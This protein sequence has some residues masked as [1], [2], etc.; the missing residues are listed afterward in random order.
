MTADMDKPDS[1]KKQ[2]RNNLLNLLGFQLCWFAC[3]VGGDVWAAGAVGLF[4]LWHLRITDRQEW[5]LIAGL[6]FA[7]VALDT[8]WYQL[9]LM[10]FPDTV[11]VLIP[12]WLMLL[13]LAFAATLRHSLGYLFQ[14]PML[15]GVVSLIAAPFSYF[16]GSKLGAIELSSLTLVV[17]GISWGV[18]MVISSLLYRR[19]TLQTPS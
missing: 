15:L 3:V 4:L 1:P 16:A 10:R 6:G 9:G 7:G 2:T 19:L 14:R 12:L 17:I 11:T 5:W 18:L 8:L 13:W